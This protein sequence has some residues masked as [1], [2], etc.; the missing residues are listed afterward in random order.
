TTDSLALSKIQGGYTRYVSAGVGLRA[1]L[2]ATLSGSIV[3]SELR[4]AYG[5]RVNAGVGIFLTLRPAAMAM[6]AAASA[7]TGPTM[8]M[9]Q[10]AYDPAKLACAAGF[11]PKKAATAMYEGKT[12]Y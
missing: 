12:Y 4:A 2:G 3:P 1:G 5:G 8:V 9:V 11:D 10:T 7:S 6:G